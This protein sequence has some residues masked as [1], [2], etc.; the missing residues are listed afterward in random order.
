MAKQ[1]ERRSETVL[2]KI[3]PTERQQLEQVAARDKISL[4]DATRR[5][6]VRDLQGAT[7]SVGRGPGKAGP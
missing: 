5:A 6:I 1:L 2:A 7:N 4:S 3:T